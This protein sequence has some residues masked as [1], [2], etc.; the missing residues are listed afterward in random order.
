MPITGVLLLIIFV[1]SIPI[2]FLRPLYGIALWTIVAFL[3]PQSYVVYWPVAA[4]F[5]W[6]VVVGIPTIL[7]CVCFSRGWISRLVSR[8]VCLL[9][10]L[11]IWFTIT[12]VASVHTPMFV[13]HAADTWDRW[14]FVSKILLMT[15]FI[16]GVLDNFARLRLLVMTVA[17]CFGI[18][19][20][21]SLPFVLLTGGAFRIYGPRKILLVL[22]E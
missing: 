14:V 8:E 22:R 17:G 18:Y 19:V 7:G 13:H 9:S 16:I 5:P 3:N 21:K 12:T 15:F 6:A 20:I 4:S 11:W 10:L 2:C 1:A